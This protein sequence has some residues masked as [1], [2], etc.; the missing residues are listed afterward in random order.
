MVDEP[1][2]DVTRLSGCTT[3]GIGFASDP[4]SPVGRKVASMGSM[5]RASRL[6]VVS[7]LFQVP[8]F[9]AGMQEMNPPA[10][11]DPSRMMALVG[12]RLID[13]NGG[14]PI[15]NAV[16]VLRGSKILAAGP[17][18]KVAV[19]NSTQT[20]DVSGLS[21]LPGLID[22]HFHSRNTVKTPVEFE[23]QNGITSFRDPGHPFKYYEEVLNSELTMPRVFLC[24]GHLDGPPPVWPDQAE[25]IQDAEHARRTVKAHVER[26]ASAIKV[27]FR[28]PLEHVHATCEAATEHGVIVTAHL[29]LVDAD[30]AIRAGVR[31]IEHITSFGTA[32]ASPTEAEQFRA[33]V[34]ADS[35]A[36]R[37]LR[38]RLW[39]NIDLDSSPN[40]KSLVDTIVAQHVFVSPTLAI[41]EARHGERDATEVQVRGFGNMLR[42]VTL[43]HQAGARIVVG[44]HTSAPFAERGRAYQRELELLVE[45]GLTPMEAIAA[46]T[47]HNAEFFGIEE[48][49]GTI[50]PGK[51]ADLILVDGDPSQNI[52]AMKNVKHVMLN[53]NWFGDSP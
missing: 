15:E 51:S 8:A 6:F 12:A 40:A 41:F 52:A 43:C 28:L 46:G 21:L 30:V 35:N 22:S 26:G 4:T 34:F 29:E 50:E 14:T 31:G 47:K 13:G 17:R 5:N 20:V 7:M 38:H 48:R 1:L 10:E 36:R 2:A 3:S 32:L 53:G 23:L 33:A 45:A 9:A 24:G 25:L 39:A 11:P 16:V 27:Y 37:E 19:P 42:F 49:L 44:S 18:G